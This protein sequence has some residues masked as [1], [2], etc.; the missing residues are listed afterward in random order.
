MFVSCEVVRTIYWT[1]RK[2]FM[3]SRWQQDC[4]GLTFWIWNGRRLICRGRLHGYIQRT[5]KRAGIT[6]F[7]F[8]DLRHTWA[9][10][11]VQAGVPLSALQEMGGWESIEM[12]RRYA[13][14]APNHLAEHAKKL[15]S[16]FGDYDTN[17]TQIRHRRES[18][19]V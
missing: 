6:D 2:L 7:R 4:A 10:C 15:D 18:R 9:S 11:L 17:T 16:L 8:H 14:L 19:L 12:V 3:Y 5:P 1:V 13:H